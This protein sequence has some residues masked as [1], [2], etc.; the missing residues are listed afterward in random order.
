MLRGLS[1]LP[2]IC[3]AQRRRPVLWGVTSYIMMIWWFIMMIHNDTHHE[4]CKRC[5]HFIQ[6]S[7][8]FKDL[9]QEYSLQ[10]WFSCNRT[11][12]QQG[13]IFLFW[14]FK[15]GLWKSQPTQTGSLFFFLNTFYWHVENTGIVTLGQIHYSSTWL[16][17]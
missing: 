17:C 15:D 2:W 1:Y 12:F 10:N 11:V 14:G 3:K 9:L 13:S 4:M 16:I 5:V 8:I 6:N 7:G